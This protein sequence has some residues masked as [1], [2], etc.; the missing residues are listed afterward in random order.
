[1][2][3]R[4]SLGGNL[5]CGMNLCCSYSG[6]C[7]YEDVHCQHSDG[8]GT[9]K[10][11]CQKDMGYCGDPGPKMP[12]AV[13]GTSASGRKIG[14]WQSSNIH[15]RQF[16]NGQF[17]CPPVRPGDIPLDTNIPLGGRWTHL[18]YA[19]GAINP[20]TFHIVDDP[21]KESL[22]KEFTALKY[23]PNGPQTWMAVGGFDFSDP[24]VDPD[25]ETDTDPDVSTH[26]TWSD[27]AMTQDRRA[28]FIQSTMAFMEKYG[29]QG[30]DLDWEYPVAEDRGGRPEDTKNFVSLV[31]EM[32]Q[33]F[34]TNYGMSVALAPDFWYL[35]YYDAV[36]MQPYVDW[37]G[38]MAYDLHGVW[39]SDSKSKI[40]R[41]HTDADEIYKDI[42]PLAFDGLDFSKINFGMAI[43]GRGFTLKDPGCRTMDGNCSWT[44]GNEAGICT[45]FSGVLSYD[46]IQQKIADAKLQNRPGPS[47]DAT[48]MMK[49]FTW[50]DKQQNWIGYDDQE[51]WQ[52]KQASLADKYGFV[53]QGLNIS[54]VY[55]DPALICQDGNAANRTVSCHAPCRLIMPECAIPTTTVTA[56]YTVSIEVYQ[57]PSST[58]TET[59][60]TAVTITTAS[61][62]F[63]PV[64]VGGGRSGGDS[65][66]PV[67]IIPMPPIVLPVTPTAGGT[68]TSRT[69][70][71]PN[72]P[73]TGEWPPSGGVTNQDPWQ[74]PTQSQSGS[75]GRTTTQE[76]YVFSPSYSPPTIETTKTTSTTTAAG[77]M[78]TWPPGSI[79]PTDQ[80]DKD[81]IP[82]DAWFLRIC[83]SWPG[84]NF[85]GFRFKFPVPP[86]LYIFPPPD[87]AAI[88]PPPGL[89]INIKPEPHIT[90]TRGNDNKWTTP[91]QDDQTNSC[92]HSTTVYDTVVSV[93]ATVTASGRSTWTTSSTI[94]STR[95]PRSGCNLQ[96]TATTSATATI[97]TD[98]PHAAGIYVAPSKTSEYESGSEASSYHGSGTGSDSS[99]RK[100]RAEDDLDCWFDHFGIVIPEDPFNSDD[101]DRLL[102]DYKANRHLQFTK[103]WAPSHRGFTAGY[104]LEDATP[105]LENELL[106]LRSQKKEFVDIQMSDLPV[107]PYGV[108]GGPLENGGV[109]VTPYVNEGDHASQS[110]AMAAGKQLGIAKRASLITSSAGEESFIEGHDLEVFF[111]TLEGMVHIL[112][113]ITARADKGLSSVVNLSFDLQRGGNIGA[114][115]MLV[116]GNAILFE[117]YKLNAPIVVCSGNHYPKDPSFYW[118]QSAAYPDDIA[119]DY[120]PG[121][122]D[123]E[124]LRAFARSVTLVGA[125]TK[126]GPKADFSQI[127]SFVKV[128]APGKSLWMVVENGLIQTDNQDEHGTSYGKMGAMSKLARLLHVRP[129]YPWPAKY[130]TPDFPETLLPPTIWNGQLS[131]DLSC[132]VKEDVAKMTQAQKNI[133]PNIADERFWTQENYYNNARNVNDNNNG[134]SIEWQPGDPGPLCPA[135]PGA[136]PIRG[137]GR[138][139]L[140]P[141]LNGRSPQIELGPGRCGVGCNDD[142]YCDDSAAG[143]PPFYQ[144]PKDPNK[145]N[146]LLGILPLSGPPLPSPQPPSPSPQPPKDR[147]CHF[148][149]Q[150]TFINSIHPPPS[151]Q[152]AVELNFT[153][154]D[155]NNA[156]NAIGGDLLGLDLGKGF[157]WHTAQ[158]KL[159]ADVVV[160]LADCPA[161]KKRRGTDG[162]DTA[163][164]SDT[165]DGQALYN[166]RITFTTS[167]H[168]WS[169]ADRDASKAAYC[170]VGNYDMGPVKNVNREMDCYYTC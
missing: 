41:G 51:T 151:D 18:Y 8:F 100:R 73:T 134:P 31:R 138:G 76:P 1:M 102:N 69:V 77:V 133:C 38:F 103:I 84:F 85:K 55:I 96:P 28:A 149:L 29:F 156:N 59:I 132:L 106:A 81:I 139:T 25:A 26:S 143:M 12:K 125:T 126:N 11:D 141:D 83:F 32:R 165:T 169:S 167:G 144:D 35:R 43:Y 47:L 3:G 162:S 150:E 2:C 121:S 91:Q 82:C 19:F 109:Y 90:L 86:G 128:H 4:K 110:A 168:T 114:N 23:R 161:T 99:R 70:S 15:K 72:W 53:G 117:I 127:G 145:S 79:E 16:K 135:S 45:D 7:G 119:Y 170:I 50:G 10:G 123:R 92:A 9:G 93:Q 148:H 5:K 64:Y 13:G 131:E 63:S 152:K 34:G 153:S 163:D 89:N 14:Y 42:I 146:P 98:C 75:I 6:W 160:T 88:K 157:V 71:L 116:M 56:T 136:T 142:W 20:T 68:V 60:T 111:W 87:P 104:F 24:G 124:Q 129:D 107:L 166:C 147:K 58:L 155:P 57:G 120:I 48:T 158:S 115:V 67:P 164:G 140:P 94:L 62:S 44:G 30:I 21:T 39:A 112:E 66:T 122:P 61:I 49:Y 36:A 33:A 17:K 97:N 65:F 54:D 105:R 159:P 137:S 40:V 80:D 130:A 52:L 46:E 154:Y 78:M 22:Y 113:S 74:A 118:P 101:V 108:R 95:I 37:F 27:M